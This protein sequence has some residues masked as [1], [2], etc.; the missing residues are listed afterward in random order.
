[1]ARSPRFVDAQFIYLFTARSRNFC[2]SFGFV[3]ATLSSSAS[4]PKLLHLRKDGCCHHTIQPAPSVRDCLVWDSSWREWT[5]HQARRGMRRWY[6]DVASRL[7]PCDSTSGGRMP[8]SRHTHTL[9][10]TC[11][12][13]TQQIWLRYCFQLVNRSSLLSEGLLA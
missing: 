12:D 11:A 13:S 7:L 6:F 9:C 5:G 10:G 4:K 1:M 2:A 3:S 8:V